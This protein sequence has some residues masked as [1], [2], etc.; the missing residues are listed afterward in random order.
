MAIR[1]AAMTLA[2]AVALS[3]GLFSATGAASLAAAHR[4]AGSPSGPMT[5]RP[6]PNEVTGLAGW[7]SAAAKAL[8]NR[9]LADQKSLARQGVELTQ[10]GPDAAT[11]K[12]KVYLTHYSA[13]ARHALIA[14]YGKGIIVAHRSLPRPARDGRQ[15]D[16]S[17]FSGGDIIDVPEGI[18]TSGPTVIG[19]NSGNTFMLTAGHCAPD[20]FPIFTHTVMMGTVTNVR[21]CTPC[22][23]SE[24]VSGS[25]SD[26]IWGGPA[27]GSGPLYDEDGS[28]FPQPGQGAG[29]LVTADGA[30]TGEVRGV[31]VVAVNQNVTFNDGFTTRFITQATKN[32]WTVCQPG[33]SGGPWM[34]HEGNTGNVKV[35]GTEVGGSGSTC[36]YEQIDAITTWFNVSVP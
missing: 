11:G 28:L 5:R 13:T 8:T 9:I 26:T 32:G 23:D 31:T 36:Y 24:T 4:P 35:V 34:Q 7:G 3:L 16:T 14:R 12:V 20:G 10:W 17:P 29:S 19:N 22:I 15:N 33:D 18:C 25:Y 1:R 30:V 2:S 21:L 27:N 6:A